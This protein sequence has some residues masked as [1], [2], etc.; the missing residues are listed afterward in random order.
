MAA[1]PAK[2]GGLPVL[3]D[4][5]RDEIKSQ[6]LE[7]LAHQQRTHFESI[8]EDTQYQI[9]RLSDNVSEKTDELA[10]TIAQGSLA[11]Q[12]SALEAR[13]RRQGGLIWL[14]V[15]VLVIIAYFNAT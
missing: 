3:L 7:D 6:S 12:F 1:S 4:K 11:Q 2:P 8:I 14:L 9:R 10:R 5:L 15:L 13:I